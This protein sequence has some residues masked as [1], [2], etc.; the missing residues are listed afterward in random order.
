[1]HIGLEMREQNV[2]SGKCQAGKY[3][4]KSLNCMD[5]KCGTNL[6]FT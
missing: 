6:A 5:E 2:I 3:R 1:M 4:T